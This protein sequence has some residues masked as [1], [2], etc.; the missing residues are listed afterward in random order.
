MLLIVV[1]QEEFIGRS[2][3]S[4]P[5]GPFT[6]ALGALSGVRQVHLAAP[7]EHRR[8]LGHFP[9]VDMRALDCQGKED[10]RAFSASIRKVFHFRLISWRGNDRGDHIHHSGREHMQINSAGGAKCRDV[11]GGQRFLRLP[12]PVGRQR[13]FM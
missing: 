3:E 1:Q 6:P 7:Q 11:A 9:S 4:E 8:P 13:A 5:T 2:E 10:I 12:L